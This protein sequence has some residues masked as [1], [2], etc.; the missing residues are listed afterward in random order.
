[1][2]KQIQKHPPL[3]DNFPTDIWEK[4][5]DTLKY[6]MEC[7]IRNSWGLDND[8]THIIHGSQPWRVTTEWYNSEQ[9][10]ALF[11][12]PNISIQPMRGP[13]GLIFTGVTTEEF[14]RNSLYT[15]NPDWDTI[16]EKRAIES[17]NIEIGKLRNAFDSFPLNVLKEF[18][19]S[20]HEEA[21]N[22]PLVYSPYVSLLTDH[23]LDWPSLKDN[24]RRILHRASIFYEKN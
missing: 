4:V 8:E 9:F 17:Y 12:N 16:P 24:G 7:Y 2:T 15:D 21:K 20:L 1:M 19:V 23:S 14:Y 11:T 18:A 3:A 10:K 13:V 22:K 6:N 5:V